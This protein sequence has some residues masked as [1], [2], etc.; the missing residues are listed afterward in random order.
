MEYLLLVLRQSRTASRVRLQCED[1]CGRLAI[2]L[3]I[4][5]YHLGA[6]VA[7]ALDLPWIR[8]L[9][10]FRTPDSSVILNPTETFTALSWVW[11][12]GLIATCHG[13]GLA[14]QF[15]R[16]LEKEDASCAITDRA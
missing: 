5:K 15:F 12:I 13:R 3:D 8:N 10:E 9:L 2:D 7:T 16:V 11:P 14:S 4:I 6:K 1:V